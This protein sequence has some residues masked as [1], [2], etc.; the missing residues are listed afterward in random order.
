[1]AQD[2][3]PVIAGFESHGSITAG[4]RFTDVAGRRQKFDELF[5]LRS[6]FRVHDIDWFARSVGSGRF[7]D[8][9]SVTSSGLGGD[10]YSTT[11]VRV[12]RNGV[13]EAGASHRQAYYYWDRN[14]AAVQPSGQNGLTPNHDFATVRR[15][16]SAD[17]SVYVTPDLQ[18]GFEYDRVRREGMRLTTRTI[19]YFDP[20]SS[21]GS[22]ARANP[23]QVEAPADELSNRF[24]GGFTWSPG[25]WSFFYRA[26]YQRYEETLETD[27][28][29]SSQR[30]LNIDDPATADEL[31]DLAHWSESRRRNAPSSEFSYNGTIRPGIRIRGG[32][33]YYRHSGPSRVD[34]MF[35][36]TSRAD[37]TGSVLETY[38]V[39]MR[40]D[41]DMRE[42][43]HVIDQGFTLDLLERVAFHADYRYTRFT[44]ENDV[45]FESTDADGAAAGS[46]VLRWEQGLHTLDAALEFV[47]RDNLLLRPGIR[48]IKRDVTFSEDGMADALASRPS[49][50]ASPILSVYYAPAPT[51]TI[52]GDVRSTTNG[53]PYTRVTPRTDFGG[54]GVVRY[55]PFDW[56][57]I[58]NSFRFRNADYTT[59][60][61]ENRVRMNSTS[62]GFDI[63][64]GISLT[65]GFT[66]DSYLATAG[67]EFLR[68]TEPREVTWRDQT[69]SRIWNA[70]LDLRPVSRV[71]LRI[72]GNYVRT[73]GA[74]EIS[75]EAPVFG[76]L[77]WPTLHGTA[78]FAVPRGGTLAI[79]LQRTYYIEE[80]VR[81]DN[82]SANI[83]GIRWTGSF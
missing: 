24:T 33:L 32:Y 36:G 37:R 67:I 30:S 43:S 79:D 60:D 28:L 72:G 71:R 21:W 2:A 12:R 48:L 64:E 23:Y 7:A 20:P 47:P 59:T 69:I 18:L 63:R 19:E 34:A 9:I 54:R 62:I 17:L 35:E 8:T 40:V 16:G 6:G 80:I 77:T 70:N 11:T 31:L 52:R 50:I 41:G 82:F 65:G 68:G 22:F 57:S 58:E 10:P 29:A 46:E 42:P 75:G 4:Y 66:Y 39:T 61:F 27:N 83:L 1:M 26:G 55:S 14:D 49:K 76:P 81:G 45:R 44:V 56:M 13:W 15:L 3:A 53:G 73:N 38:M 5:G 25:P 78:E 74:G 51:L